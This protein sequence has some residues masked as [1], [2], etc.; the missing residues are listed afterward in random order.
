MDRYDMGLWT[1]SSMEIRF[2]KLLAISVY[3]YNELVRFV[4]IGR[5]IGMYRISVMI[6]VTSLT[7]FYLTFKEGDV[8]KS[9]F[10]FLMFIHLISFT[11]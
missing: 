6:F 9:V 7:T 10:I 2:R 1:V 5:N 3:F 8:I 4:I 11:N